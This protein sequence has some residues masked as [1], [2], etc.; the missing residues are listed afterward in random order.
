MATDSAG[1]GPYNAGVRRKR[2]IVDAA[3]RVFA[4]HG[5]GAS[6]MKQ[7]AD[8]VGVT[9][10][11][12]LRYFSKQELLTE[13]LMHWDRNQPNFDLV[14]QGLEYFLALDDLMR[15]HIENRGL[16]ELYLTF[17]T[18]ATDPSHPAHRF[19]VGRH[20]RTLDFM[21]ANLETA[22]SRGDLPHLDAA[23]LE[24]EASAFCAVLDGLE[25]QWLLDPTMD[26][27]GTVRRYTDD[28]VS[29]WK[30]RS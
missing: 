8:E 21:R 5:Y 19:L 22:I 3:I 24:Y 30:Q 27:V 13:V 6:T 1:R 9:T 20:R 15:F 2:E 4:T 12:V 7:I 26:L 25:I 29:R 18:E 23:A 28:A 17:V 14:P 10:A 16:L 11:A